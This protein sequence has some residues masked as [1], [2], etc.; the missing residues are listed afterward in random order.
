M[1][2]TG[3]LQTLTNLSRASSIRSVQ[4]SR[5]G[6]LVV[7]PPSGVTPKVSYTRSNSNF[8]ISSHG[9]A[10]SLESRASQRNYSKPPLPAKPSRT[11]SRAS[12]ASNQSRAS[13]ASS[14]HSVSPSGGA[15]ELLNRSNGSRASVRS[16]NSQLSNSAGAQNQTNES[17]TNAVLEEPVRMVF[18]LLIGSYHMSRH[19]S[20]TV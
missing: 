7:A 12:L 16:L 5:N 15:N 9:S 13:I 18:R 3:S 4:S 1:T 17:N 2:G 14:I 11:S 19:M 8:S 20:R 10:M 6:D